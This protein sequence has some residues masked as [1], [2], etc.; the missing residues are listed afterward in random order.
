MIRFLTRRRSKTPAS[1]SGGGIIPPITND[2]DNGFASTVSFSRTV[3]NGYASTVSFS[4]SYNG[5][6]A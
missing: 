5:G 2:L 4:M 3:D 6:G 1:W